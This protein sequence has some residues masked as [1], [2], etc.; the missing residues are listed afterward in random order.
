MMGRMK[1]LTVLKLSHNGLKAPGC[2]NIFNG[3]QISSSLR[4]LDLSWNS[5]NCLIPKV[6]AVAKAL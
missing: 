2:I 6:G 4:Y 1:K 5:M 3:V